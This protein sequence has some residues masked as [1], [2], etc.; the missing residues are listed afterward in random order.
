MEQDAHSQPSPHTTQNPKPP[1]QITVEFSSLWWTRRRR[2]RAPH[3]IM[4]IRRVFQILL[5]TVRRIL[6]GAQSEV[7]LLC[8]REFLIGC[9]G[10]SVAVGSHP[11]SCFRLRNLIAVG[12]FTVFCDASFTLA[13]EYAFCFSAWLA[14]A[15][16]DEP[17]VNL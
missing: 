8:Q 16:V 9:R 12:I 10:R 4:R 7:G 3:T 1:P 15:R 17:V 14:T 6:P 11:L 13:L 2:R 5:L